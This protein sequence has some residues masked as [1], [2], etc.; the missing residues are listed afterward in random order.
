MNCGNNNRKKTG[1]RMQSA[2]RRY[3]LV[4]LCRLETTAAYEILNCQV[5]FTDQ[6]EDRYNQEIKYRKEQLATER[7]K[8]DRIMQFQAEQAESQLR[9]MQASQMAQM[10][11]S[12]QQMFL[13]FIQQESQ[14]RHEMEIARLSQ[15]G[16]LDK[17]LEDVLA[18]LPYMMAA[19]G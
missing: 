15:K 8:E 1:Q 19:A 10:Q 12:N 3:W 17:T 2:E 5:L 18:T 11:A 13:S 7:E 6:E 9:A 4:T 16:W 14:R